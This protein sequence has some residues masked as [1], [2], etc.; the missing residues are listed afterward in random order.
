MRIELETGARCDYASTGLG[1]HVWVANIGAGRAG[2]FV[3]EVNG[4]R[5]SA[6]EGLAAGAEKLFWF[7]GGYTWPGENRAFVDA[8]YQVAESNESNNELRQWLPIPT[9]PPTCTA[10][11]MATRTPTPNDTLSPIPTL[12]ETARPTETMTATPTI[13]TIV[14]VIWL[15]LLLKS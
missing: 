1:L 11:P 13:T 7:P 14:W 10:T 8:D 6:E 15:P 12:T 2:P 4:A 5:Q 3:L 9:L